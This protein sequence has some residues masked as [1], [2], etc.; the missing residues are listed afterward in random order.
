MK[1]ILNGFFLGVLGEET[2]TDI[3]YRHLQVSELRMA[4]PPPQGKNFRGSVN[5]FTPPRRREVE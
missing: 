2:A 5:W 4:G 3:C 1:E